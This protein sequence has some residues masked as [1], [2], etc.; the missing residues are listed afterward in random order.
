MCVAFP[1]RDDNLLTRVGIPFLYLFATPSFLVL[2]VSRL[3]WLL[4]AR[5]HYADPDVGSGGAV[6]PAYFDGH[7]SGSIWGW[8]TCFLGS[9]S[10]PTD[11]G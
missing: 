5:E 2:R 3:A 9:G 11:A 1:G 6:A 4:S 7:A 8:D 10:A